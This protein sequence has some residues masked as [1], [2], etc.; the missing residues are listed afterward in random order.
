MKFFKQHTDP[1]YSC[2]YV[3]TTTENGKQGYGLTF[4]CGRGTEIVVLTIRSMKKFV[5][6][7]NAADIFS[8]F[9]GFWRS[10]TNDSQMRWV[11]RLSFCLPTDYLQVIVELNIYFLIK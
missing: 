1:N 8:D 10:I 5:L 3:T 4:T 2:A 6:G 11:T 7:R 9:A